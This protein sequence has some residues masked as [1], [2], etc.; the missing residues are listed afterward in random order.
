MPSIKKKVAGFI[1]Q[2]S[3]SDSKEPSSRERPRSRGGGRARKVRSPPAFQS[4]KCF[5]Q[6][7]LGGET[8]PQA[9]PIEHGKTGYQLTCQQVGKL[10]PEVF[11]AF[12]GP[13]GGLTCIKRNVVVE[14][15]KRPEDIDYIDLE[16]LGK[17]VSRRPSINEALDKMESTTLSSV[18]VAAASEDPPK[19]EAV[20]SKP[21]V[22]KSPTFSLI[23][24]S[25]MNIRVGDR[26]YKVDSSQ[27]ENSSEISASTSRAPAAPDID[28]PGPL[29]KTSEIVDIDAELD[30]VETEDG[31]VP[32][33]SLGEAE[34]SDNISRKRVVT[35]KS[36][37]R[38]GASVRPNSLNLGSGS[39][40]SFSS[41]SSSQASQGSQG[42]TE[43]DS[44]QSPGRR[45]VRERRSADKADS[46]APAT[47]RQTQSKA[48][49][50]V[51]QPKSNYQELDGTEPTTPTCHQ[52]NDTSHIETKL[53][54]DLKDDISTPIAGIRYV[55]LASH[56][57]IYNVHC[58][59]QVL[60]QTQQLG[61]RSLRVSLRATPSDWR[62]GRQSHR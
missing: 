20:Q 26:I 60:E 34:D 3:S 22:L 32:A 39:R 52:L 28:S 6:R 36:P 44:V 30:L 55:M 38:L 43:V 42:S 19:K 14:E 53:K 49:T 25:V 15:S 50:P 40:N 17:V 33:A 24:N 7:Y 54:I 58:P 12:T 9:P 47:S 29:S 56:D 13:G 5:I 46:P 45:E 10:N 16:G 2:F 59:C 4:E 61:L 11:A 51:S 41:L 57:L 8:R 21:K 27:K 23:D 18:A 31:F 37:A 62:A 48:K 35:I 1:R